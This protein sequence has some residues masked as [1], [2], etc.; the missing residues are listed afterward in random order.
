MRLRSM[1]AGPIMQLPVFLVL[2]FAPVYVPLALLQGWIH[3]VATVNPMTRVIES[4]RGFVAGAPDRG[5]RR[6]RRR[7]RAR[8]P[9]FDLGLPR[10]AQRRGGRLTLI[11]RLGREFGTDP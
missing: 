2:F 10:P 3:G 6:L 1:Q 4:G 11:P 8:R 9:V 7:S 5:R